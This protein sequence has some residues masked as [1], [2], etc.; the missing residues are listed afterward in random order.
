MTLAPSASAPPD[1]RDKVLANVGEWAKLI[2]LE[3][4]L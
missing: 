4:G 3:A 2:A 1:A